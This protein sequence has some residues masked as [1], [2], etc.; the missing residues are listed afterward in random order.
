MRNGQK[1]RGVFY[2]QM[3]FY[4]AAHLIGYC[5]PHLTPLLAAST[6]CY[7]TK[8]DDY[9]EKMTNKINSWL[10]GWGCFFSSHSLLLCN[11]ICFHGMTKKGRREERKEGRKEGGKKGRREE[12]KEGRKEGGKKGRREERKEGRK[13]NQKKR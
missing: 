1:R 7:L 13:G 2:I 10:V 11:N 5:L 12:R 6:L 8:T 3:F 9:C 4:H